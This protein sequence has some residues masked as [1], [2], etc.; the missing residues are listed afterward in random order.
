MTYA[1]IDS[2]VNSALIGNNQ[3]IHYYIQFLKWGLDAVTELNYD[4]LPSPK[5]VELTVNAYDEIE[6][7]DDYIDW[8]KVGIKSGINVLYLLPEDMYNRLAATSGGSQVAYTDVTPYLGH[9]SA[10]GDGYWWMNFTS[11]Y[12]EHI[13]RYYGHGG[14]KGSGFFKE[15]PERGVIQLEPG[16]LSEGDTVYLE[17]LAHE[18]ANAGSL[19]SKYAES[20][21]ESYI[22]WQYKAWSREYGLGDVDRAERQYWNNHRKFRARNAGLTIE[23]I[24]NIARKHFKLSL[25]I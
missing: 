5:A 14:G 12:G 10:A 22:N 16:Y 17:Y 2:I 20:T 25:K 19:I 15:I 1:T 8:I 11:S 18:T 3:T 21:I 6:I 24:K 13:G 23:D 9:I 7:P 4:S